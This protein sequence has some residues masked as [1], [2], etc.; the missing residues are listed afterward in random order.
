MF[1][2]VLKSNQPVVIFIIAIVISILW[3]SS[4]LD[5]TAMKIPADN[6]GMPFYDFI[7][8]FIPEN[9][10]ISVL[11]ALVLV[12]V[13]SVLLI[14][15]NKRNIVINYR[16]YLPAFFYIIIAS[17]FIPL[18]RFN[19]AVIGSF[20]IFIAISFVYTTYRVDYALNNHYL[21]GFFISIAALFYAPFAFFIIILW[22]S[23]LILRPFIG[24]EWLV[25]ILGFLTPTLFVF[26]YYF[27]FQEDKLAVYIERFVQ[28][29]DLIKQFSSVQLPYY[30]LFG[31]IGLLILFASYNLIIEMQKKK[32][33]VRKYFMLNWWMFFLGILLFIFFKNVSYE[34]IYILAIPISFLF[35]DYAYLVR[36]N[37]MLNSILIVFFLLLAYIQINALY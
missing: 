23:L 28:S 26:T 6:L 4:L 8:S 2:R 22:I 33:K 5:P 1:I 14:Q 12:I 34:I 15:F 35:S 36:K 3:L 7:N 13:Q 20:F 11:M 24:R 10:L 25:G 17:S 9:S 37:W 32:I 18:Q 19:P 16:T 21:A 29:F 31:F 27:V 30:L